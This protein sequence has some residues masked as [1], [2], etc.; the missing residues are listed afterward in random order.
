LSLSRQGSKALLRVED[1]GVGFDPKSESVGNGIR[2]V[3]ER[4]A[5]LGGELDASSHGHKVT[6][7]RVSFP[8][9]V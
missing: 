6:R 2:N 5:T 7:L 1:D 3:R 8:I 9:R 4:A